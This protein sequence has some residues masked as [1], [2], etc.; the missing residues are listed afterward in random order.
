MLDENM[1][2]E[3]VYWHQKSRVDWIQGGD[4]NTT[5]FHAST[6]QR[7]QW[8]RVVKLKRKSGQWTTSELEVYKKIM[9][10]Y[11][12]TYSSDDIDM[13][14]F[15][16]AL[17]SIDP[18]VPSHLNDSLCV[19]PTPDEIHSALKG[20][21]PKE[22]NKTFICLIPKVQN[23]ESVEHFCPISLCGLRKKGKKKFLAIKIDLKKAYD[24]LEWSFVKEILLRLGFNS[25]WVSLIMI[26]VS[27]VSFNVLVNGAEHGEVLPS[28]DDCLLFT[29]VNLRKVYCLKDC[30]DIFCKASGLE[31]NLQKSSLTFSPNTPGRIKRR[32]SKVLKIPYGDDPTKYLGLPAEFGPAKSHLFQDIRDKVCNKVQGSHFLL[33][34]THH[35]HI[36]RFIAKFYWGSSDEQNNIHWIS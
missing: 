2:R 18:L 15:N 24:R 5:F 8:N 17:D 13:E 28:R 1:A 31:V 23:S 26:C 16:L 29:E 20:T 35:D 3:E 34:V 9:D 14:D 32:F 4:K 7:R 27:S 12:S 10:N 11:K 36:R 33:L 21:L 25:Q 30:L 22:L 19:I 6:I